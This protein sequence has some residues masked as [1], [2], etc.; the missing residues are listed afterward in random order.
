VRARTPDDE[1]TAAAMCEALS[2][3]PWRSFTPEMLA[4]LALAARDR[5]LLEDALASVPGAA[6]GRWEALEPVGRDD[7]RLTQVIEF[8]GCHR[9]TELR[10]PTLCEHLAGVLRLDPS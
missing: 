10:L 9:W 4:R 6:V 7:A 2:P 1:S 5:H 8:L 3:Y